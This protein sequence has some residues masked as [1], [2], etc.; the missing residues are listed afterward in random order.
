MTNTFP[1]M[2][3][4]F[5]WLLRVPTIFAPVRN[6]LF[7][8]L[9]AVGKTPLGQDYYLVKAISED[10]LHDSEWSKFLK[11]NLPME[12]TWPCNARKMEGFVE[13]AAQALKAKFAHRAPQGIFVGPLN[14]GS[15]DKY[16]KG[17]ASNLRGRALQLFTGLTANAVEDQDPEKETL[18]CLV[19]KEGLFCGMQSPRQ[20]QGFYPGGSLFIDRDAPDAISRAGA[21]VAEA[22]HYLKLYTPPLAEG[23]PCDMIIFRSAP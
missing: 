13:N 12:H 22:L 16:Y 11:W 14:P 15:P 8:K 17:L 23:M 19:G 18:F 3:N 10:T 9:E 2:T 21:K 20:C 5:P 7:H 1:W 6:A 4:Y